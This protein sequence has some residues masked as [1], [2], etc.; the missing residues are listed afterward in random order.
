MKISGRDVIFILVVAALGIAAIVIMF[1]I[2]YG[3]HEVMHSIREAQ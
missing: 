3:W 2:S 1:A